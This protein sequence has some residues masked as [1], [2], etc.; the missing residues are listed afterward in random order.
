MDHPLELLYSE[1]ND[2]ILDVDLQMLQA[3]LVFTSSSKHFTVSNVLF[4]KYEGANVV[5]TN[6]M[7]HFSMFF[8]TKD[9]VE[10][11]N[12]NTGNSQVIGIILCS[13]N[14]CSIIYLVGPVYYFPGYPSIT[15]SYGA[16]KFYVGSQKVTYEALEHCEFLIL[17][18]ILVNLPTR[19]KT[20]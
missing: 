20:I 1:Q 12:G 10:L 5:V 3:W 16:L 19:L 7:S 4:C 6:C 2:D 14:N 9:T 15:I 17:R 8:P 11:A 18:V 13:F